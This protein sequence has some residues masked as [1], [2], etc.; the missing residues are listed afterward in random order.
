MKSSNFETKK[1]VVSEITG[2]TPRIML[3]GNVIIE[4]KVSFGHPLQAE[5]FIVRSTSSGFEYD[6]THIIR[7]SA[8]ESH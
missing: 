4:N 5:S 3:Y 7:C 1:L 8:M 6:Y 2:T